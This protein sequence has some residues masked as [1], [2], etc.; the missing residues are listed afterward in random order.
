MEK[1]EKI[2]ESFSDEK[3]RKIYHEEYI[4]WSESGIL[5]DGELR[6]LEE[7]ITNNSSSI[8]LIERLFLMDIVKRFIKLGL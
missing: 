8:I 7:L 4:P 2:L 1:I 5:H 3:I 6:N